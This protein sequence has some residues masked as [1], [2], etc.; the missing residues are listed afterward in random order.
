M[1]QEELDEALKIYPQAQSQT[2]QSFEDASIETP[3]QDVYVPRK[4]NLITT[5]PTN[6]QLHP[7]QSTTTPARVANYR[8]GDLSPGYPVARNSLPQLDPHL[9]SKYWATSGSSSRV[10]SSQQSADAS[11]GYREEESS[12][13]E[14]DHQVLSRNIQADVGSEEIKLSAEQNHVLEMVLDGESVFFTGSAGTG[15]SVLLREI[16]RQLQNQGKNVAVTASTGIAAINIGGKT[17][18][19]FAGVGLG[20]Q[21]ADILIK[22]ARN[23][24]TMKRWKRTEVLIIDESKLFNN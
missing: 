14:L 16:I 12:F 10:D 9:K 15:K 11:F 24:R 13:Q 8:Q 6:D 5:P 23:K 17:L 22:K 1:T 20:N 18:H 7:S 2:F 19:S 3:R 4:K 21:S